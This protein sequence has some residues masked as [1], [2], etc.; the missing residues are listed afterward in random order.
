MNFAVIDLLFLIDLR[1]KDREMKSIIKY[2]IAI[3]LL[4]LPSLIFAQ[5]FEIVR[6][7]HNFPVKAT[8]EIRNKGINDIKKELL[9]SA[10]GL[11][12]VR[13]D[14]VSISY[15][16]NK[17]IGKPKEQRIGGGFGYAYNVNLAWNVTFFKHDGKV[18]N[19]IEF[20][21]LIF[22]AYEVWVTGAVTKS[23]SIYFGQAKNKKFNKQTEAYAV[24][25]YKDIFNQIDKDLKL[26][27][28]NF[29]TKQ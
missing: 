24:E 29:P 11:K 10:S 19:V 22:D 15:K 2:P 8:R 12:D 6:D 18:Y 13:Q 1:E 16:V 17:F 7:T 5:N 26:N 28:S 3:A 25:G 4:I 27:S 14:S 20:T 9:L 23:Q 21:E